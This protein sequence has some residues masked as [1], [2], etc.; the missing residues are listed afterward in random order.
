MK[1][2]YGALGGIGAGLMASTPAWAVDLSGVELDTGTVTTLAATVLTGLG[3][4]W[5]VR[6]VIKLIN[7]S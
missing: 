1:K 5:G 2:I 3:V 7:R 6:K 4:I